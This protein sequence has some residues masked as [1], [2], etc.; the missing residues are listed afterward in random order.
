VSYD[1]GSEREALAPVLTAL[2]ESE[3]ALA[4]ACR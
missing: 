3:D 4:A 2:A 1:C